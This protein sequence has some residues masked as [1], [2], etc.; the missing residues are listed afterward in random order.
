MLIGIP[1]ERK[2]QEYRIAVTPQTVKVLVREGHGVLIERGAGLGSG[3]RDD[4]FLD[5]GAILAASEKEVFARSKLIVKVKEPLPQEYELI[6]NDNIIFTF[7]HL[8]ANKELMEALINSRSTAI[9]YETVQEDDGSLP[10]L[11]QMS[12]IAG[13]LSVQIGLHFL[14]KPNGGKGKLMRGAA[15]VKPGKITVIGGGTVGYN[16]IISSLGNGAEVTVVDNNPRKLDFYFEKFGGQVKTLSSYPEIIEEE[17]RDSDIVI[18][19]VL[20]PGSRSPVVIS[21]DMIRNMEPGS[22]F[23]DL[24][25]DQG[26]CSE[27]SRPTNLDSPV[28]QTDGVIHYCVTNVPSLVSKTA[29]MTLA[30]TLLPYILAIAGDKIGECSSLRKGICVENGNLLLRMV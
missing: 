29:S 4:D 9:A 18:G 3:F 24:A 10:I 19:A 16:A 6:K 14:E 5:A 21:Q 20:I 28:Y 12:R 26:G 25:I 8:A 22:V 11:A 13:L 27:T 2:I 15:G 7:L 1:R 30:N 23:V 17:L